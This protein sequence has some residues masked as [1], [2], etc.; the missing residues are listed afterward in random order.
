VLP[1]TRVSNLNDGI[2]ELK[3]GQKGDDFRQVGQVAGRYPVPRLIVET[4]NVFE[5]A[6]KEGVKA[7]QARR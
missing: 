1:D 7:A 5:V 4:G 3:R 6:R 2:T